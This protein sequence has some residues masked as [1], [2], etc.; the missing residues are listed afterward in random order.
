MLIYDDTEE[1]VSPQFLGIWYVL[2]VEA[3]GA[4]DWRV[5]M[6]TYSPLN[7]VDRPGRV[8]GMRRHGGVTYA[9]ILDERSDYGRALWIAEI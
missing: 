4:H 8:V 5:G 1:D 7:S 3:D 9:L 2:G 6:E